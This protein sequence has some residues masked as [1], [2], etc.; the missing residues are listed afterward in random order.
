MPNFEFNQDFHD[1]MILPA[2]VLT[3]GNC[4]NDDCAENHWRWLAGWLFWSV[5]VVL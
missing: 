3:H 2:L 4:E 1:L 5:E